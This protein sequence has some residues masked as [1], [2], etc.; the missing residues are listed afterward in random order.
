MSKVETSAEIDAPPEKVWDVLMDPRRLRDWVT[1]HRGVSH[2]SDVPLK[3]GST[4]RQKLCLHGVNFKVRWQVAELDEAKYVVWEGKGPALSHARTVY[5][6][7]P[8]GDGG[9]SFD[10]VNEFHAPGGPLGGVAERVLVGSGPRREAQASIARL[11]KLLE[12]R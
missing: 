5:K 8:N 2:V 1:I 9:T 7:T 11:K 6:L 4:L 3:R 12:R 10:Y